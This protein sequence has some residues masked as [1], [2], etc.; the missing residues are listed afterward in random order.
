MGLVE[1][2][3]DEYF[4]KEMDKYRQK[5]AG[6]GL[7]QS[8]SDS[9]VLFSEYMLGMRLY[10]WQV[11]FL[12]LLQRAVE[13]GA[14]PREYLALTSRQIGKSTAVA[15]FSL[16]VCTFNKKPGTIHNNTVVGVI[17]ATDVQA[18]KLLNEI[19]KLIKAGDKFM[20]ITYTDDKGES[21][22]GKKFFTSLL[23]DKEA[24]NTTTVTFKPHSKNFGELLLAGSNSGSVIKS[25]PP[26]DSV[27]GETFTIVI[28]DEAGK[29]DKISDQFHYEYVYPTGNS[30]NAVRVYTSTPWVTSGFFYRLADPSNE[31]QD[32]PAERVMFSIDAIKLENPEYYNNVKE[33]VIDVM[34]R[35]GKTDEVQRAYYCRFVKGELA[36]FDNQRVAKMFRKDYGMLD[37]T[38]TMCDMGVDFGGESISRTVITISSYDEASRQI[39]RLYHKVYPVGDKGITLIDDIAQLLKKFNVQRIIP[40]DCPAGWHLTE[41]MVLNGWEV[42]PMNFRTDKVKK[43]GAFRAALN[44]NEIESYEDVELRTEMLALEFSQGAKNVIIEHA[45]GYTDDLIDSFV[46]SCY[47]FVQEDGGFKYYDM[48][49]VEEDV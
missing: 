38:K 13:N 21:K 42:C 47:F 32:H 3:V 11:Y 41:K 14:L 29:S 37:G 34:N 36:Y 12:M 18:K 19:K 16:W 6:K 25:Y 24:N 15:V 33:K 9:V 26:T 44:R 27:L 43:Y 10:A 2:Q 30:T 7:L 5:P 20:E 17:S 31:Y 1:L 39:T 48:N 45:P 8:C 23:D 40:D 28:E 35:D 46:M 22:F 49:D 4:L